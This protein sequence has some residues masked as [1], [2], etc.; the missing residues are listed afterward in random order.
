MDEIITS[1]GVGPA[2]YL[3]FAVASLGPMS[4]VV[5]LIG[6]QFISP[7]VQFTC[8]DRHQSDVIVTNTSECI[9]VSAGGES[10]ETRSCKL[11]QFS[12]EIHHFTLT[13]EFELVCSEA[14]VRELFQMLFTIG[15]MVGCPVGGLLADKLGRQ[16][17]VWYGSALVTFF[18][19]L[20]V[21]IPNMTSILVCRFFIGLSTMFIISPVYTIGFE[22][23]PTPLRS[24]FGVC[25]A[26][27]YAVML[28]LFAGL[29]YACPDWRMLQLA[30]SFPLALLLLL[31]NP[32]LVK[33]SPRWLVTRGRLKEAEASLLRVAK[34]NKTTY[35]LPDNL[36]GVLEGI[37]AKEC[38]EKPS[39][40]LL[41]RFKSLVSSPYLR[42]VTGILVPVWLMQSCL[43][44]SIPLSADQFA[45]PY[46]AMAVLGVAE[47]PAYTVTAPITARLGRKKF[48][49]GG[50]L[51]TCAL[52]ILVVVLTVIGYQNYWLNIALSA[53]GYTMI[54]SVFQVNLMFCSELFPTSI[55][56]FGTSLA[57]FMTS[58]GF[59]ILP[60]LKILL[61]AGL[62]WLPL[63]IYAI[64]AGLA[65]FLILLLPETNN[66][67]LLQTLG[68]EK[69]I[70]RPH[71]QSSRSSDWPA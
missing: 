50:L 8:L 28:S 4:E 68:S 29:A 37:Y 10:N 11:Y 61:P 18:T 6:S 65:A 27:P 19:T 56:S 30:G 54:C 24:A 20:L 70:T 41:S 59:N 5:N 3:L 22:F 49:I 58:A 40:T 55:R 47:I 48:L 67:P 46:V 14:Y 1:L 45:S 44:I 15:C 52:Q 38:E 57:F 64:L 32:F 60:L 21:T 51:L 12:H 26:L 62:S 31:S 53:S 69:N 35:N 36:M 25:V 66:K 43:Y 16:P 9:V 63:T 34:W 23:C 33:E 71:I 17:T 39:S 7:P 42:R 2:T 13:E